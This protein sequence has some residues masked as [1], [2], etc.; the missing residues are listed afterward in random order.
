MRFQ[1]Y[2]LSSSSSILNLNKEQL[3]RNNDPR[4]I[5]VSP[6]SNGTNCK[7]SIHDH[8][9]QETVYTSTNTCYHNRRSSKTDKTEEDQENKC[10]D[11]KL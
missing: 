8:Q 5:S 1:E 9:D 2:N 6:V 4:I 11:I 3:Q 10:N 7:T